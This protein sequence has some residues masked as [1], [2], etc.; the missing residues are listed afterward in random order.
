M[1]RLALAAP[2]LAVALLV[3]AGAPAPRVV[4]TAAVAAPT[5]VVELSVPALL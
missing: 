2:A 3:L 1:R 4:T 5:E